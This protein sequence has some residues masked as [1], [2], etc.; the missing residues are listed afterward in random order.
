M[1]ILP[2]KALHIYI[3]TSHEIRLVDE[4]NLTVLYSL[5]FSSNET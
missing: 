4:I 2:A 1:P 5:I 3:C